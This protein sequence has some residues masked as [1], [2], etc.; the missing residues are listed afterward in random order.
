MLQEGPLRMLGNPETYPSGIGLVNARAVPSPGADSGPAPEAEKP[1]RTV[2]ATGRSSP[3]TPAGLWDWY[4]LIL[5]CSLGFAYLLANLALPRVLGGNLNIYIAQ[6]VLWT[7]VAAIGYAGWR[8]GPERRPRFS[9]AMAAMGLLMGC[10]QTAAFVLLGLAF[11]FGRSPYSHQFAA[12]LGN[13]LYAGSILLAMEF[14]RAYLVAAFSRGNHVLAVS[15]A[16]L[17]FAIINLPFAKFTSINDPQA[18]FRLQGEII[19]PAISENLLASILAFLGGPIASL[20]YMGSLAAFEWLSPVL[21]SLPWTITA[22]LG[23]MVPAVGLIVVRNQVMPAIDPEKSAVNGRDRVSTSWILVA[24]LSVALL[25]FNAGL[26]GYQP[27][28]VSGASMQPA[29]E[30]GDVVVTRE[31]A[32]EEIR[33]GDIVRF[34]QGGSYIIHRVVE[35]EASE[36]GIYFVTQGDANNVADPPFSAIALRGKVIASVPKIGW[37]SIAVRNLLG[38]IFE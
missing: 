27:T 14:G 20:A 3:L 7:F 12:L 22:F 38:L 31:V 35:I 19:L 34:Q 36:A 1:R 16:A 32:P 28:L 30:L 24:A 26:L 8:Y 17:L 5:V 9:R 10:F 29:L 33:V 6:P 11:G 15:T 4:W 2:E 25:W 23:T 21:P 18:F 37:V 13:V